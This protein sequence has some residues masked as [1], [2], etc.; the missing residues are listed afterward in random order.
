MGCGSFI[1][2]YFVRCDRF[3]LSVFRKFGNQGFFVPDDLP[4]EFVFPFP[5][6][7]FRIFRQRKDR[8]LVIEIGDTFTHSSGDTF[9]RSGFDIIGG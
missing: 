9:Q 3:S 5:E 6:F 7:V 2:G 4:E 1:R 8:L